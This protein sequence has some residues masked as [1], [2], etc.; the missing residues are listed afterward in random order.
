MDIQGAEFFALV[1]SIEELR[2]KVK[3]IHVCTHTKET[4]GA[5]GLDVHL[6]VRSLFNKDTWSLEK[7]YKPISSECIDG[8]EIHYIDGGQ[9][10]RNTSLS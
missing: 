4:Q 3:R 10:W 8:A 7:D 5:N 9:T 6:E 1:D 2:K